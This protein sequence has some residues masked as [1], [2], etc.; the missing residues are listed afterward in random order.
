MCRSYVISICLLTAMHSI[1]L[2]AVVRPPTAEEMEAAQ[3]QIQASRAAAP[4]FVELKVGRV[5]AREDGN[6]TWIQARSQVV[7]VFRSSS[8]LEV[9]DVITVSYGADWQRAKRQA[10]E[11]DRKRSENPGW[12]G[13]GIDMSPVI[14][15]LSPGQIVRA[16]LQPGPDETLVPA[17]GAHSLEVLDDF[18][19]DPCLHPEASEAP[20]RRGCYEER[21]R[22]ATSQLDELE[23]DINRRIEVRLRASETGG[24]PP[25]AT[26]VRQLEEWLSKLPGSSEAWQ[27]YRDDTCSLAHTQ[28]WPGSMARTEELSCL[29]E[30]TD[31]RYRQLKEIYFELPALQGRSPDY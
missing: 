12:A 11:I 24:S 17:A 2:H 5:N 31:E 20:Q 18:V 19:G 22:A 14:V 8:G 3:Q 9:N 21:F 6:L 7:A 28:F 1:N 16:W 23:L 25:D 4:E 15:R 26:E 30:L 10:A 29:A 13:L 27:K